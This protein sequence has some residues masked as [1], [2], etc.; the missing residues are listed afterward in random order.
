VLTDPDPIWTEEQGWLGRRPFKRG[1]LLS[2]GIAYAH[3]DPDTPELRQALMLE[4]VA[5]DPGFAAR[6][7]LAYRYRYVVLLGMN[8]LT[9]DGGCVL[10]VGNDWVPV[11]TEAERRAVQA[12]L[13]LPPVPFTYTVPQAGALL[14]GAVGVWWLRRKFVSRG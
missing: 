7:Q 12:G 6:A 2:S 9:W 3:T 10:H 14:V 4:P 8:L 1:S 5:K 11:S 13:A